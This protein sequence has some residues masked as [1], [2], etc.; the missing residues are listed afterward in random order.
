M[1]INWCTVFFTHFIT[2]GGIDIA[3]QKFNFN[4]P[5]QN[6]TKDKI[7]SKIQ[8]LFKNCKLNEE[9]LQVLNSIGYERLLTVLYILK[10]QDLI[11]IEHNARGAG[12]KKKDVFIQ[13]IIERHTNGESYQSIADDLNISRR[14]LYNRLEEAKNL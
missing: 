11:P 12:R 9:E 7:S 10:Q 14:T 4:I 5:T 8:E 1:S 13:E 3:K 2:L 6:C